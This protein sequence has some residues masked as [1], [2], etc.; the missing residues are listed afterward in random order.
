MSRHTIT[1]S[2]LDYEAIGRRIKSARKHK[3]L[4]QEQLA[5]KVNLSTPHMSHI[6]RGTT[7]VSLPSLVFIANA[8]ETTVDA[9]LHD[10]VHVTADA[11]DKDFKD[12]V[13]GCSPR[14][15]L[16]IYTA[17]AEIKK[18]LKK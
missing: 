7:K 17:A 13:D 8:L 10:S 9:L 15:K 6:E 11:F 14:E 16:L 5:E 1:H 3:G 12:L 2:Q 4:N 18:V